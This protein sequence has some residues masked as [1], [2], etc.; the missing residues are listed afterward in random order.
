MY[1]NQNLQRKLIG[2][3]LFVALVPLAST[4][5]VGLYLNRRYNIQA[6][7]FKVAATLT[8]NQQMVRKMLEITEYNLVNL[9][10][11]AEPR[12]FLLAYTRGFPEEKRKTAFKE[13]KES[14][15]VFKEGEIPQFCRLSLLDLQG[16]EVT[17][18]TKGRDGTWTIEDEGNLGDYSQDPA[19]MREKSLIGEE[20]PGNET[21]SP[22]SRF[23]ISTSL[24]RGDGISFLAPVYARSHEPLGF[25]V[26]T[27]DPAFISQSFRIKYRGE[28]H[29]EYREHIYLINERGD[30]LYSSEPLLRLSDIA[31]G[32]HEW[33]LN[34]LHSLGLEEGLAP[35]PEKK[36]PNIREFFPEA[37]YKYIFTTY[38]NSP[39]YEK[40]FLNMIRN[41][42]VLM[43]DSI[44]FTKAVEHVDKPRSSM[45]RH[46]H[47][48]VVVTVKYNE[49]YFVANRIMHLFQLLLGAFT[50]LSIVTGIYLS[51]KFLKPI[52]ILTKGTE[53]IARGNWD[54]SLI[55]NTGDEFETL[56][57]HFNVMVEHLKGIYESIEQKVKERTEQLAQANQL[58]EGAKEGIALE[59]ERLEAVLNST[60]EGIIMCD[61]QGD[62][63][64]ANKSCNEMFEIFMPAEGSDLKWNV[65]ELIKRKEV[66]Q[67]PDRYL[68]D[69]EELLAHPEEVRTG[70]I[71]KILPALQMIEWFSAPVRKSEGEVLGRIIAFRDVTKEK[72]VERMK[73]EFVSIVSHELRTPMTAINGSLSLVLDGTVGEINEDQQ[74]LLETAKNNTTRLIRL[75][76]DILDISKIES[77][78]ITM[79]SEPVDIYSVLRDSMAGIGGFAEKYG[80]QVTCASEESIPQVMAD[81]DRIIQVVTNLLSNAIKFSPRNG[82]VH[83][84]AWKDGASLFV[85]VHDQGI[86]IPAEYLEKIFEKF[87]QVDSSAVR[88]KG[89]TGLGLPICRAIVEEHRGKMWVESDPGRGST[90]TFTL[91]LGGEG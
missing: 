74:D 76:N 69:L 91:P 37:M 64:F 36:V 20:A 10:S 30:I 52:H 72:E 58:L 89:G 1:R 27:L 45:F 81:H 85:S 65:R 17:R 73:D 23:V 13:F 16:K 90:F 19:Y 56:A 83:L 28:M 41:E 21:F 31:A 63:V 34:I 6:E 29:K 46:D 12:T 24:D 82:T 68:K 35:L 62:L 86:G 11:M 61:R 42:D 51:R 87:Q 71:V 3:L 22:L 77:G 39:D 79:K 2:F 80:V 66:F 7:K 8:L 4:G 59:K 48:V 43:F 57:Y 40:R 54:Y 33:G 84:K 50:I 44:A 88:E 78:K 32:I 38:A 75:I 60:K 53:E 14:F 18:G 15:V 25:I 26:V 9:S 67:S 47:L 70:Q 5:I 55:I 49:M